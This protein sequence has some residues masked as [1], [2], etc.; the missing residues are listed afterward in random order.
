MSTGSVGAVRRASWDASIR[1]SSRIRRSAARDGS[2]DTA[3]PD[4]PSRLSS[5]IC[6][7]VRK[8]ASAGSA[9][10]RAPCPGSD[11]ST[12]SVGDE[13]ASSRDAVAPDPVSPAGDSCRPTPSPAANS[14]TTAAAHSGLNFVAC[15]VGT[16]R[17]IGETSAPRR[18]WIFFHSS[19]GGTRSGSAESAI[20]VRTICSYSRVHSS[21][22]P[23]CS[24]SAPGASSSSSSAAICS[25]LR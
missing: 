14:A 21:Q 23:R 18:V 1:A 13:F 17:P 11:A 10:S 6:A 16:R 3:S 9:V 7:T 20:R 25:R 19:A 15:G 22:P 4:G 5:W 8:Y 12:S 2:S 24:R